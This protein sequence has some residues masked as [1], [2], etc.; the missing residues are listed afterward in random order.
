MDNPWLARF[1]DVPALVAPHMRDRFESALI[2]LDVRFNT[3]MDI[4]KKMADGTD[5]FWT[6]FGVY[7]KRIRPYVVENGILHL[8]VRGVLLHGFPYQFYDMATGY[9]YIWKAFDRGLAD[10]EV[11][12]IALVI[13][14]PGGMVAGNFDLVDRM[15]AARGQKPVRAFASEYAFSAAYSIASVA[16][17]ITLPRTG[18][19]G[20]IGVVTSHL[21]L[22]KAYE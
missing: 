19:V 12:G 15:Y 22:S 10:P 8:P 2:A 4:A 21:D 17:S 16:D 3:E 9:E 13:D 11:K 5:E 6:E 18:E 1:G 20:S 7:T 14:S